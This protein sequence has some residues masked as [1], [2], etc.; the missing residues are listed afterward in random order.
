VSDAS[1][2]DEPPGAHY[3]VGERVPEAHRNKL[4]LTA[5]LNAILEHAVPV[6]PGEGSSEGA[7]KLTLGLIVESTGER[8]F[9]VLM[10]FLCLPFLLPVTIPGTSMPFGIALAILGLQLAFRKHRPWLPRR[11]LGW[12]LPP[13]MGGKLI[14]VIA[15]MFGPLERVIR[16]RWLFMQNRIW[17]VLVGTALVMD[18]AFLALPWPFFIPLTNTIP[19]WLALIKV[20]GITEEDG[21]ALLSGTLL[22]LTMMIV[23]TILLVYLFS[24]AG[25][26]W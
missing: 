14:G 4:K 20:L 7:K 3:R 12:K 5:A 1:P 9:G 23:G 8:A 11:L 17:M 15:K 25:R 10:A 16:P 21:V 24:Q 19:A 13:K 26:V 2:H 18:G 22:T 6:G